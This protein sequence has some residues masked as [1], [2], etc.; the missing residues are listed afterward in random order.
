MILRWE[1]ENYNENIIHIHG[2]HDHTIP[3]VNVNAHYKIEKGSHVMTLT[4]GEELNKVIKQ[5][6]EQ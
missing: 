3:I 1:R 4:R 6:L 5:T 2:T